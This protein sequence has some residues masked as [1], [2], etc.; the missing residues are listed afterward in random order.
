MEYDDEI[1]DR[2][3]TDRELLR[4]RLKAKPDLTLFV[5]ETLEHPAGLSLLVELVMTET[6]SLRY[7]STKIIR[8]VSEEKPELVY[9]YFDD[10][11][12][13][14]HHENSF[15]KWDGILILSN[16]SA[17]DRDDKF[18]GIYGEYFDLIGDPQMITAGNVI[19]N[20]WKIVLARPE[21]EHDI[22][23]RLLEVPDRVYLNKGEPS[24]ECNR[25]LCGQ[26]LKCFDHYFKKA[27]DQESLLRFAEDQLTC[28]RKSVAKKAERFLRDHTTENEKSND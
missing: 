19:G 23:R 6:T 12:K 18:K 10:I 4:L 17:V 14:I 9:P 21:L 27:G 13:W 11:A 26:V 24:P 7:L 25:I 28:S 16:L 20:A 5:S 8:M 3:K 15:I 1:Q 22:T 2:N